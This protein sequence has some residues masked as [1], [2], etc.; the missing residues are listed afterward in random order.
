[1][2]CSTVMLRSEGALVSLIWREGGREGGREGRREGEDRVCGG[3]RASDSTTLA[4]QN[5]YKHKTV[6]FSH[7]CN[8]SLQC[9]GTAA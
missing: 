8:L 1:M 7:S 2:K 6:H 9:P 4:N 3:R 5:S